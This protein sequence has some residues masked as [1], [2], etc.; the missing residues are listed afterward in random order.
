MRK[1]FLPKRMLFLVLWFVLAFELG[2]GKNE[3]IVPAGYLPAPSV[4]PGPMTSMGGYSPY[5]QNGG[6]PGFGSPYFY[7]QVPS[8]YSN[9]YYPFLPIDGYMRQNASLQ[10]Y[11]QQLWNGWIIAAPAMGTTPYDFSQFWFNYCPGQW[12]NSGLGNLYDYFNNNVYYWAKP[13][14]WYPP[15][16]NPASFW[17]SYV[18]FPYTAIDTSS[19]CDSYCY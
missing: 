18:G 5:G 14:M 10:N 6:F 11:W 3:P 17:S 16:P 4:A 8:G 13:N 15:N 9:Q 19:Y 2:C 1:W 7:P 12:A